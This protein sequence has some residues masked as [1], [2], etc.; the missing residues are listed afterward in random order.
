MGWQSA[1]EQTVTGLGYDLVECERGSQGLLRV[2]IDRL[3]GQAYDEPGESVTVGDC[4]RVT[5]QLQRV[6]EVENF[7]YRRLEV[8]S[9]GLD[10]LLITPAH[11]QRFTGREVDVTLKALFQGR[12]KYRGVLR[13]AQGGAVGDAVGEGYELVFAGDPGDDGEQVLGFTLDEVREGRLVPVLNFK[14]KNAKD[15]GADRRNRR[16]PPAAAV[17]ATIDGVSDDES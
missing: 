4:E 16:K 11:W 12:R 10:R 3:P 7:D 6:F 9:P 1:L 15:A 5:R 8:T 17:P 13:A 14:S 2:T